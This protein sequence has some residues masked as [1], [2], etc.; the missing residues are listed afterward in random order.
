MQIRMLKTENGSIDGIR[1]QQYDADSEYDLSGSPGAVDLAQAFVGA[2][3]AVE[4][5]GASPKSGG[6]TNAQAPTD[7]EPAAD[8]APA[9]PG[10]KALAQ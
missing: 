1:V 5:G 9:K 2:G 6:A 7:P 10:R 8:P 3:L 4:A